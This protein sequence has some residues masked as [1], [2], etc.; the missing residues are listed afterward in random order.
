[1]NCTNDVC[2]C[3][4]SQYFNGKICSKFILNKTKILR[5]INA[6]FK[7]KAQSLLKGSDCKS[8]SQCDTKKGL[9]CIKNS[10]DCINTS[11]YWNMN[12]Q[13]CGTFNLFNEYMTVLY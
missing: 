13:I 11:L 10:C 8:N 5:N 9:V 6:I 3:S 2:D 7:F 4:P 12:S 1:L